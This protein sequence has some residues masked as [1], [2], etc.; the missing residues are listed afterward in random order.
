[1]KRTFIAVK[2]EAEDKLRK[3]IS[4]L[5]ADLKNDPIKWVNTDNLHIT[6]AFLGNTGDETIEKVTSMLSKS[7]SGFG[8]FTLTI[9][10]L[11]IFKNLNDPRV[12]WAGIE[13]SDKFSNLNA[14]IKSGLI[15]SGMEIES[16][17][18][19]P[20]LTLGRIKLLKSRHQLEELILQ[21]SKTIF[22]EV[23][24]KEI[25]FYESK[26]QKSGHVYVPLEKFGLLS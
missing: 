13:R 9:S 7:C 5:R 6:L 26:F 4:T 8:D 25:V 11:G 24:I 23:N 17:Q 12:L 10:G 14:I 19:K 18:F 15:K 2:V 21:Y 22:Q 3:L 1:M 20:H 16:G